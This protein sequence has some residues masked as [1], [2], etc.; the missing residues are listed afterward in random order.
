MQLNYYTT[1]CVLHTYNIITFCRLHEYLRVYSMVECT[2]YIVRI[3]TITYRYIYISIIVRMGILAPIY[4]Y[5][6]YVESHNHPQ[7]TS[8]TFRS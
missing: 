5:I 2:L 4:M 7:A 6:V 3:R 8:K 1:H